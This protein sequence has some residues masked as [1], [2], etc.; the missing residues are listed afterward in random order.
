M[1]YDAPPKLWMPPRPAIIRAAPRD[2]AIAMFPFPAFVPGGK[3]PLVSFRGSLFSETTNVR[4][5]STTI[6]LGAE[7]ASRMIVVGTGC[8][9]GSAEAPTGCTVD[10]A[11][12]SLAVEHTD[13]GVTALPVQLWYIARPTG[14]SVTVA[15]AK[16][17]GADMDRGALAVWAV[18][19]LK[20]TTPADTASD[21]TDAL[22]LDLTVQSQAAVFA[23]GS[24]AS[25]PVTWTYT[26]VAADAEG[27]VSLRNTFASAS[28]GSVSGGTRTITLD[29]SATARSG[30]SACWR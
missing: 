25:N 9:T 3:A 11:A 17:G 7:D 6:D 16:P 15:F 26:G 29:S 14:G 20:S 28:G 12:A 27:G 23:V 24:S 22:S 21:A 18:Y 10:G 8:V 2:P 13:A 30:V 5:Y 1:I 19:Y 4:T